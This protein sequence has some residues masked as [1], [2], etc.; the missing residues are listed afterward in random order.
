LEVEKR[1]LSDSN[2]VTRLT[3][4]THLT[5]TAILV[6]VVLTAVFVILSIENVGLNE[7]TLVG[8]G[9][10]IEELPP[11]L[12]IVMPF[13]EVRRFNLSQ[14][15]RLR[16]DRSLEVQTRDGKSRRIEMDVELE[17][18]RESV[19]DLNRDY[20][21][22]IFEKIVKPALLIELTAAL[23]EE[24]DPNAAIERLGGEITE[25]TNGKLEPIGIRVSSV[26][27]TGILEGKALSYDL[28]THD[29]VDL[30]I[31]GLD[32]YD[33][34][35]MERV[36]ES[37]DLANIKRVK[38]EGAW[39]DLQ[40]I[41][42]L[43]S[44]LIW[45]TMV[46]GVTPD[47]HGITDFLIRDE[48]T[49]EDIPVT[50]SMR[51]V[52]AVWNM[53]SLTDLSCGFIGWFAS[54]PAEDVEGFIVSD[55]FGYHMFDPSWWE[56]KKLGPQ[57]GLA[58]PADIYAEIEPLTVEVGDLGDYVSRYL[59][60]PIDAHG[61]G[62]DRSTARSTRA[63][64]DRE[65][66]LRQI[67]SA[68]RTYENVMKKLYPAY[69]PELF[70]IYFEFTDSVCH[71]F[72]R[73]MKPAM[74][75]VSPEDEAR[76][77]G[78][79][80]ATYA[81]ADRILGDVLDMIDEETVL[82]I[83]SDHGFKSGDFRPLSDSRMGFGQAIEWHRLAGTIAI[84]GKM[85]K[86]GYRI[87][88]ASVMDI[89]PTILYLLG[90]PVDR[91][92]PGKVLLD[93]FEEEWVED[94]PVAYTS[95]YDSLIVLTDTAVGPS[96]ADQALK[97]KLASL[98]YIAGGQQ[99]L[100]N[101]ASY[102]HKN[103]KYTEALDLYKQLLAEEPGNVD[104]MIAMSDA[105]FKMGREDLAVRGLNEVIERDPYNLRAL[106][107]LGSIHAERGRGMEAL[108]VAERA[109]AI[110]AGNGVSHFIKGVSLQKLGRVSEAIEVYKRA[111]KLAPDMPEI[112]GN[113]AQVYLNGG[114]SEEALKLVDRALDLAPG[115]VGMLYIRG[116]ALNSTGQS[117]E[118][119]AQYTKAMGSDPSFVPA[120]LGAAGIFFAQGKFDSVLT[121]CDK[122]LAVPSGYTA[123]IYDM[124]ANAYARLERHGL[125]VEDFKA[126]VEADP[127]LS[128][129]ALS[130]ARTYIVQGRTWEAR[131]VL[132]SLLAR[133]PDHPE[134]EKLLRSL[135]SGPRN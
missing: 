13:R 29:G 68:Y 65:S 31:L 94:H 78:A 108:R 18:V 82:L 5:R 79:I 91:K 45:T 93:A 22:A 115:R 20:G 2:L 30:F 44:P 70:G 21:E 16:G 105:Y 61:S 48:L 52:P 46:T 84:Y 17:L 106:N 121:L 118:A 100:V 19:R 50:S 49:G 127:T 135:G 3:E 97:D 74:D 103:G 119:L 57:G 35:I 23:S 81:E 125:A 69:R 96:A 11:G 24:V 15:Q 87:T 41:E 36:A 27:L 101:L 4:V 111:L 116:Q 120:Y 107:N 113:L 102:Y 131:D 76:Y 37:V 28:R 114:R 124:R 64:P 99:T 117:G 110:D 32:G 62:S 9:E 89:A 1:R 71:L 129:P 66:S 39:G 51:R 6:F 10:D 130:L 38:R 112:Y 104:V 60:G 26:V 59:H 14:T 122:A 54:F 85:V 8:S 56:G 77:G 126:A 98:G 75:G 43:V 42:P 86:A 40:S 47:I 123:Y 7:V 95:V 73:F 53:T 80:A 25:R 128:G 88:D 55:R 109:L 92:M 90:M 33:W 12:N 63:P 132:Q 72:M 133:C 34:I 58:F 83:V 134:G 67:I